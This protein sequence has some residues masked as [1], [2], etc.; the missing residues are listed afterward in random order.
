MFKDIGWFCHDVIFG[1]S[2]SLTE[3]QFPYHQSMYPK[4]ILKVSFVST[5]LSS[6][7]PLIIPNDEKGQ[8]D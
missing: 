6:M 7:I 4:I 5:I 8:R 2:I 1:K 3:S